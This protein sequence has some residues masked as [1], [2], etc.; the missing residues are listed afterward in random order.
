MLKNDLN[1]ERKGLL[2]ASARDQAPV[3]FCF[4]MISLMAEG[5]AET[6][7]VGV[8]VVGRNAAGEGAAGT[9]SSELSTPPSPSRSKSPSSP[10]SY[11]SS[12][13][14]AIATTAS[15]SSS[16]EKEDFLQSPLSALNSFFSF[17]PLLPSARPLS[18]SRLD[19][20]GRWGA[21]DREEERNW[22]CS[23]CCWCCAG[24]GGGAPAGEGGGGAP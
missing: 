22:N 11:S 17:N 4:M 21:W 10:A 12:E 20:R 19:A 3:A 24:G 8:A 23:C 15:F 1:K 2:T 16:P 5:G 14:E 9:A 18:S 6:V 7:G 13:S